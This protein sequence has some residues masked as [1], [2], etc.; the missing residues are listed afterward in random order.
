[1][2]EDTATVDALKEIAAL[3]R[4][5]VEQEAEEAELRNHFRERSAKMEEQIAAVPT[6][7]QREKEVETRMG[8]AMKMAR[9]QSDENKRTKEKLDAETRD[10]REKLLAEFARHNRLLERIAAHLDK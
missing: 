10:F 8:D 5:R 7:E 4:R 1:M 9:E 6:Y 2:N 3:L